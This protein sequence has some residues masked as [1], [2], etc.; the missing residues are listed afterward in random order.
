MSKLLEALEEI[1]GEPGDL[2]STLQYIAQT[3]KR[4]FSAD[5]CV[6]LPINPIT[7][8]FIGSLTVS[9]NLLKR[10]NLSYQQ[11]RPEG[12]TQQVL[13]QGI[14]LV[15]NLEV[16]PEYQNEFTRTERIRSFAGL[17]LF[18]RNR[19]QC[20]G[21]FYL[22]FRR[23]QQFSH[24]DYELLQTF[25]DRVSFILQETWLLR[26][27]QEVARIGQE[28]NHELATVDVLFEKLRKHIGGIL[29]T[30][31]TLLLAVYQ[32][33]TNALDLYSEEQGSFTLRENVP[34]EGACQYVIE[35]QQ[36]LYIREMG[37]E[38]EYLEFKPVLVHTT[39]IGPGES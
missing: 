1:T 20:L 12:V 8:K 25:A 24:S 22:N 9:D 5:V 27:Y 4:F 23:Q 7:N 39:G 33:Q 36:L 3:A 29:D 38:V 6:I 13:K 21:A 18:A 19:Q 34:L 35:T 11:P 31:D 26:R 28:I 16:A 32:P 2:T 15:E 30:S 10:D 37:K 14:L 17:A